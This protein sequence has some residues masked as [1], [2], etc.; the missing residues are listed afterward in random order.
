MQ[1]AYG[2]NAKQESE[3]GRLTIGGEDAGVRPT[4]E[5]VPETRRG[6]HG[7]I[8]HDRLPADQ[9]A[10][11]V[12]ER[13]DGSQAHR[14]RRQDQGAS[15]RR[16]QTPRELV[17]R[18][19]DRERGAPQLDAVHEGRE[20]G[21]QNAAQRVFRRPERDRCGVRADGAKTVR[22][23]QPPVPDRHRGL[24]ASQAA[25]ARVPL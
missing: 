8:P 9:S 23:D 4:A 16:V 18:K 17:L 6:P 25:H 20:A 3:A 7:C 12:R 21:R 5:V 15:R 2:A 10:G 22:D 11:M 24:P 1:R 19:D 13:G 14:R